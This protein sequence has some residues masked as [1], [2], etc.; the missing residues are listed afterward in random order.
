MIL[1]MMR[2]TSAAA[3]NR[4]AFVE[5]VTASP[6]E[7]PRSMYIR[8]SREGG[9]PVYISVGGPEV[10]HP[11]SVLI[12]DGIGCVG[13]TFRRVV[14]VL[15]QDRRVAMLH[16]RGHGRSPMPSRPWRLGIPDLADDAAAAIDEA[17][18]GPVLV[19]GYSMGFQVA[20]E[21]YRRYPNKVLGLVSIAGPPGHTLARFQPT[22]PLP[23]LPLVPLVRAV[24]RYGRGLTD[25]VWRNFVP[26][27]TAQALAVTTQVDGSRVALD[28]LE[29]YARQLREIRPELFVEMLAEAH[30][31][32]AADLLPHIRVPT[33]VVAG[34]K[35]QFISLETL[36]DMAFRIPGAEWMVLP[37]ASHALPAEYPEVL[38]PKLQELL[39][40]LAAGRQTEIGHDQRHGDPTPPGDPRTG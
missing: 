8:V 12:L 1:R 15:A 16:Y 2:T 20:L 9:A 28:D 6:G 17:A 30:R 14:P 3:L 36:R 26:S 18:L 13:W 10:P 24:T 22:G 32:N 29:Y 19:V 4:P 11:P 38:V 34:G 33:L 39:A 25:R 37:E 35:D 27:R 31:H 40:R 23:S 5:T 7:D 21:L